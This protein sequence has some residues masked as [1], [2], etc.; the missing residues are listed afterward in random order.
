MN[1]S[2]ARRPKRIQMSRQ[3]PWRVD[4]PNAVIVARPSQWGNPFRVGDNYL[5]LHT[6]TR[7]GW[8]LPTSREAG[9]YD[10]GLTVERCPDR[11][12]AVQWFRAWMT[13]CLTTSVDAAA[14]RADLTLLAGRD[15]ACWCPLDQPCHADVLLEIANATE[16]EAS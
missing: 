4:N 2:S 6:N 7:L 9:K 13:T 10:Y 3:H 14:E 8:P 16:G 5:W 12:T 1:D 15:L 11:A